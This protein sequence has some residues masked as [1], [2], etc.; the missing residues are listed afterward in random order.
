MPNRL[1]RFFSRKDVPETPDIEVSLPQ[2]SMR[3][4][5]N[6]WRQL[7]P[8]EIDANV[9]RHRV[10]AMWDELGEIQFQFMLAQGLKP[11]HKLLDIGCGSLRGEVRF[12][13]YL[14][15]GN[16]YG[17]DINASLIKAGWI[18]IDRLDARDKHPNLLL[19]D[20]FQFSEFD[21][22]FDYALAFSVFTHLFNNQIQRCLVELK[23]AL[24]PGGQFFATFFE[25]PNVSH[26]APLS[27]DPGG[28]LPISIKSPS[29]TIRKRSMLS[30]SLPD[31]R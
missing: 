1:S 18:E 11:E 17:L 9:H 4:V 22:Q 30:Q 16:Y 3:G 7:T 10:G 27:H 28:L 5:N 14:S 15:P 23:K 6:Y 25:A 21:A 24:K 12:V 20:Q 13:E 2:D 31:F 29:I 19:N 8:D 26:L